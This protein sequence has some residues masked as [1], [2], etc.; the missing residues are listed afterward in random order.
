VPPTETASTLDLEALQNAVVD[1][2]AA[3]KGQ[4]SASDKLADATFSANGDALT[5][6]TTV[7]PT[8][9][10]LLINADALNVIKSVLAK[11][12]VRL[13]L[14]LLPGVA[15]AVAAPKPKRAAAA[16]SVNELVE[17]HPIVEQAKKLFSAEIRNVIDLRDKN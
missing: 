7:S 2:L 5:I 15:G 9:L 12:N 13:R 16:G 4:Q 6:Q 3:A 17:K 1:A 10:P 8:M 14:N 11:H